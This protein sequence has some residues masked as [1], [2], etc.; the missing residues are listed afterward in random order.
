MLHTRC[1]DSTYC[2][3]LT[4]C[5]LEHWGYMWSHMLAD[6]VYLYLLMNLLDKDCCNQ[7]WTKFAGFCLRFGMAN[8]NALGYDIPLLAVCNH[9]KKKTAS[10]THLGVIVHAA[11]CIKKEFVWKFLFSECLLQNSTTCFSA[12]MIDNRLI[13]CVYEANSMVFDLT[14]RNCI[15]ST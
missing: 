6:I 12:C 13:F 15:I 7:I 3:I 1:H 11:N 14:K 9:W 2:C 4:R 10:L 8:L 5:F